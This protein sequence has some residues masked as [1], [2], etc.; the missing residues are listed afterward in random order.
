MIVELTWG[1]SEGIAGDLHERLSAESCRHAPYKGLDFGSSS[2]EGVAMRVP[3][4]VELEDTILQLVPELC[5]TCSTS[6]IDVHVLLH[7]NAKV[8]LH[9][10]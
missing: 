3:V 10:S 7:R 8:L 9:Y 4:G 1:D 5:I 2:F 6:G